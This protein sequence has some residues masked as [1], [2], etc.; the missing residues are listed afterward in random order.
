MLLDSILKN[1]FPPIQN[2]QPNQAKRK[3]QISSK[4]RG[5]QT[6]KADFDIFSSNYQSDE[7]LKML[8]L[9]MKTFQFENMV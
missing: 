1:L 2:D 3:F 8:K 9:Q 4:K 6:N 7:T 5:F